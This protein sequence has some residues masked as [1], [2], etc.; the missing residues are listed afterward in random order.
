MVYYLFASNT[1]TEVDSKLGKGIR[2]DSVPLGRNNLRKFILFQD[3]KLEDV[4]FKNLFPFFLT[5]EM[6]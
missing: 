5:W 2:R 6:L 3:V 1:S 4:T